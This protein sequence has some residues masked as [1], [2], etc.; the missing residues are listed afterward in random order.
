[1]DYA[2]NRK[3]FITRLLSPVKYSKKYAN[4]NIGPRS[5]ITKI[6]LAALCTY[7]NQCYF[8]QAYY[9]SPAVGFDL[10]AETEQLMNRTQKLLIKGGA[11]DNAEKKPELEEWVI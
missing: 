6:H 11:K 2:V 8:L 9:D 3:Y 5:I 7:L 10:K 1:V 4:G